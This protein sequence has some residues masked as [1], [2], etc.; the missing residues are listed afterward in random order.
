M[1]RKFLTNG[2]YHVFDRG[3]EKRNIF[4]D[5]ND[6]I[7]FIHDLYEFND[8]KPAPPYIRRNSSDVGRPT[9]YI[10]ERDKLVNLHTF[11]LMPNHYHAIIEPIKENGVYLFVKKL[12]S[13]YARGFN[14]KH[15]R[16]GYLFQGRYKDVYIKDDEQLA[17]LVCYIHSN[18]LSLWKENWKDKKL[19]KLEIKQAI[20]FLEK[21]KWSSHLDYWG[22]KN[23]PS[24]INNKFLLELFGG[25]EKYRKFFIDWLEQYQKNETYVQELMLD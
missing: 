20:K 23:F 21:Y 15:K 22:I 5:N 24:I 1:S 11:V 12:H 4:R 7:R 13:G 10:V 16:S 18:P 25:L 14:E 6:Y 9:S 2:F 17:H 3:V 8:K 19:T